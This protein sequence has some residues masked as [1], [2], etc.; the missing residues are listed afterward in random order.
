MESANTGETANVQR[1]R[2]AG[3]A[4]RHERVRP[5]GFDPLHR[6]PL[7]AD[8]F[9]SSAVVA[10]RSSPP[11]PVERVGEFLGDPLADAWLR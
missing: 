5:A 3:Q 8:W 6:E 4:E 2:M 10:E 11:P 7:D 9:R 1:A